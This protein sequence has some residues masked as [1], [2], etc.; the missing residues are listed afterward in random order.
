MALKILLADDSMIA[1]NMGRKILVDAGY[2]V[3][4]VSNGAAAVK[5]L[6][7]VNPDIVLLDVYMPGYTGLEVCEKIKNGPTTCHIPVLLTVGKLEP[8]R[9]EDGMKVKADGVIVKPFEATDLVAVVAKLAERIPIAGLIPPP[10]IPVAEKVPP[11]VTGHGLEVVAPP[12][13]VEASVEAPAEIPMNA[14]AAPALGEDFLN[15]LV[16]G[17][18]PPGS[19][20]E[21]PAAELAEASAET[22]DNLA[23]DIDFLMD[24]PAEMP[25]VAEAAEAEPASVPQAPVPQAEIQAAVAGFDLQTPA[26]AAAPA[27][28]A[29]PSEAESAAE[30]PPIEI[31]LE[32][33]EEEAEEPPIIFSAP[34]PPATPVSSLPGLE[35]T[36]QAAQPE[37]DIAIA[38]GLMSDYNESPV[39][40]LSEVAVEPAE[41][42]SEEPPEFALFNSVLAADAEAQV[43]PAATASPDVA[44]AAAEAVEPILELPESAVE[45]PPVA[46]ELEPSFDE[47]AAPPRVTDTEIPYPAVVTRFDAADDALGLAMEAMLAGSAQTPDVEEVEEAEEAEK[48]AAEKVEDVKEDQPQLETV[49]QAVEMI[50]LSPFE[51]VEEV[52]E[53]EELPVPLEMPVELA[54]EPE[55]EPELEPELEPKDQ[56]VVVS[57][58]TILAATMPEEPSIAAVETVPDSPEPSRE[59]VAETAA[60]PAAPW[61]LAAAVSPAKPEVAAMEAASKP[62]PEPPVMMEANAAEQIVDHVLQRIRPGLVEE[63]K[64]LL[65][66]G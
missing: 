26:A 49:S 40:A 25:P 43:D 63:V 32:P 12:P 66:R 29:P 17:A 11:P 52:E 41:T 14:A 39:Q 20:S 65:E 5:R 55:P 10:P 42:A 8:F 4:P 27:I 30:M 1:Q 21:A 60:P 37:S 51:E 15:E 22:G 36:L 19:P 3:V 38:P 64:R 31:F 44:E 45:A 48:E 2:D 54:P 7:D 23:I 6:P 59:T 35:P 18:P 46:A 16:I 28:P 56:S 58:E 62:A 13:P 34:T 57:L 50:S 9:P 24:S 33:V 47:L 53:P 61:A